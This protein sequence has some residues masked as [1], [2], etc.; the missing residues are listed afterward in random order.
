MTETVID[1]TDSLEIKLDRSELLPETISDDLLREISSEVAQFPQLPMQIIRKYAEIAAWRHGTLERLPEGGWFA[2][3]PDFE[4]V[5][6][7]ESTRKQT[8][9]ALEDAL[10]DWAILKIQHGDKDLPVLEE[11]DLNVL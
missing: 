11:I 6:A 5:W 10:V 1:R 2:T 3:T 7:S 4:G 8:L 9:Q